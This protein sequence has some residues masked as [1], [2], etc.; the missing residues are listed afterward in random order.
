MAY[1]CLSVS[2]SSW[3]WK[4]ISAVLSA[5]FYLISGEYFILRSDGSLVVMSIFI[6]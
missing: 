6:I 2:L 5:V 3:L 1:Y 4:I